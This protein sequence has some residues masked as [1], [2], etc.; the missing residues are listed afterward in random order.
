MPTGPPPPATAP[1]SPIPPKPAA[2]TPAV[3]MAEALARCRWCCNI[4]ADTPLK[5]AFLG[6]SLALVVLFIVFAVLY[7]RFHVKLST[8]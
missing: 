8:N 6:F 3:A 1:P 7:W 4:N 2:V 5:K